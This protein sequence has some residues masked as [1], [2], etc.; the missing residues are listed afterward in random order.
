MFFLAIEIEKKDLREIKDSTE[1]EKKEIERKKQNIEK[2]KLQLTTSKQHFE[3]ERKHML[4][5]MAK[6]REK[7]K[8]ELTKFNEFKRQLQGQQQ[9]LRKNKIELEQQ[10]NKYE[11]ERKDL[12]VR[13]AFFLLLLRAGMCGVIYSWGTPPRILP[14]AGE[15]FVLS[16]PTHTW[17]AAGGNVDGF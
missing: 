14:T 8:K 6:A 4:K 10:M 12:E 7:Q 17:S 11:N 9:I 13:W 5:E 2:D 16:C 15:K 3:L 1:I